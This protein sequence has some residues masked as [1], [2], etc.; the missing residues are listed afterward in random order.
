MGTQALGHNDGEWR[1]WLEGHYTG[2]WLVVL[3]ASAVIVASA[4]LLSVVSWIWSNWAGRSGPQF[5]EITGQSVA[6]TILEV[7]ERLK[8]CM[9]TKQPDVSA[10]LDELLRGAMVL[11][12]SDIHLTPDQ[13][14][15]KATYRIDGVLHE[16]LLV[17]P[18]FA[19]RLGAR[20]KVLAKLDSFSNQPQDGSLRRTV[21]THPVEARV[22]ALPTSH[23][24]RVVLRLV[25]GGEDVSHLVE[26]GFTAS[27]AGQ[28]QA[29]LQKPQG[30]LYVSGPVGSGKTTTLYS[31][32]REL[33]RTRGETT[34]LVSI[35]DPIERQ[36]DFVAQSEINIRQGMT[37]P[38]TL[39]SVLRQDPGAIMLG[40]VRDQETAQI[41]TQ[42]GLT[43]HLILTTIHVQSA[44]GTFARLIEMDVEPF[45]LASSCVGALAQRLVRQ[46][47]PQCKKLQEPSASQLARFAALGVQLP[48]VEFYEGRGCDNCEGRGYS[49]RLPIA[50]LLLVSEAIQNAIQDRLPKEK[51]HE[52]AVAEG[53]HPLVAAGVKQA[54]AGKT[55]LEEVLRVAG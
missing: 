23:G 21:G 46:L 29:L 35:E 34:A 12:A 17:A 41:A 1:P 18:E 26:L 32:M 24:E 4:A 55:S 14:G 45:V 47:C 42:A 39:R 52:I 15:T 7:Q 49:G 10:A 44:A 22:S 20:V 40:E 11:S 13:H 3:Q 53:M 30:I 50:E 19:S 8:R 37:F 31:A 36:L 6:G 5:K 28:L 16:V 2:K 33:H 54:Q 27:T 43:G 51:I 9:G 38:G 25:R 48:T